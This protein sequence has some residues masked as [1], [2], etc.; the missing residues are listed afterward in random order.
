[1]HAA[2]L[3]ATGSAS[4]RGHSPPP[5]ICTREYRPVCDTLTG[6]TYSNACTA[7]CSSIMSVRLVPGECSSKCVLSLI[8]LTLHWLVA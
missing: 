2:P 5:C 3:H 7:R 6:K 1:M 8:C 4:S